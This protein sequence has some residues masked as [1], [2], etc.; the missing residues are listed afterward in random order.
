MLVALEDA[1][2]VV[3]RCGVTSPVLPE[4]DDPDPEDDVLPVA[5][6]EEV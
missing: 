2:D 1:S 3:D 4:A 5:T 6:E